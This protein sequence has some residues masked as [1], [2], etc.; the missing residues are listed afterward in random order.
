MAADAPDLTSLAARFTVAEV[1]LLERAAAGLPPEE[2]L[3]EAVLTVAHNLTGEGAP[4]EEEEDGTDRVDEETRPVLPLATVSED[5]G[6]LLERGERMEVMLL[7]VVALA[8]TILS[9]LYA[10]TAFRDTAHERE[11]RD[12]AEAKVAK[13]TPSIQRLLAARRTVN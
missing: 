3:R 6:A 8:T 5:A 13:I 12:R 2:F 11:C 7:E 10:H 1:E 4:E 9:E